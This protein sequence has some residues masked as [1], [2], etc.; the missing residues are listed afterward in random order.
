M[1]NISLERLPKGM[2]CEYL[3]MSLLLICISEHYCA[4]FKE[5]YTSTFENAPGWCHCIWK[6]SGNH[7]AIICWLFVAAIYK[8]SNGMINNIKFNCGL[9]KLFKNHLPTL[10]QPSANFLD[11]YC[12]TTIS[13]WNSQNIIGKNDEIDML[14]KENIRNILENGWNQQRDGPL[15]G[16]FFS[17][18]EPLLKGQPSWKNCCLSCQCDL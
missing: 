12:N 7:L 10:C 1:E 16:Q 4:W 15:L 17:A 18:K 5:A 2:L 9:F 11:I 13:L 8:P 6:P 3:M 14:N